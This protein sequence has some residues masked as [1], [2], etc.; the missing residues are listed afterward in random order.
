MKPVNVCAM[1]GLKL[2]YVIAVLVK[3][4]VKA[5]DIGLLIPALRAFSAVTIAVAVAAIHPP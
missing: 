3:R 5:R 4:P 1:A 2:Q